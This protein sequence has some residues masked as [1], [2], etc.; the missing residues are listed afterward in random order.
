MSPIVSTLAGVSARGYGFSSLVPDTTAYNFI[1]SVTV[2]AA[3]AAD[4]VLSDIPQ[5]YKH[6][7]VRMICK[8]TGSSRSTIYYQMNGNTSSD[9]VYYQAYSVGGGLSASGAP[10]GPGTDTAYVPSALDP[11]SFGAA[12][13]LIPDYAGSTI[14]S[15]QTIAGM[16]VNGTNFTLLRGGA[17]YGT[18]STSPITSIRFYPTSGL[19][20]QHSTFALYGIKG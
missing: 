19:L 3:N 8:V 11:D 9:Y 4:V 6:L 2:T 7:V 5:T 12:I 18:G 20:S 13:V 14:K 17:Y 15:I 16:A 10:G 1:K